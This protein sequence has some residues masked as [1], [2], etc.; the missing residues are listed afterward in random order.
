[1]FGVKSPAYSIGNS[2]RE[3][4][5][6]KLVPGPASY[7]ITRDPIPRSISFNRAKKKTFL[8]SENPG[9][10]SYKINSSIGSG[11]HAIIISR[12]FQK[13]DQNVPGPG[14]YNPLDPIHNIKYSIRSKSNSTIINNNPGP[15]AYNIFTQSKHSPR[16][17]I[18][19]AIRMHEKYEKTPGP[20]A[21]DPKAV[22]PKIPKFS[23]PL[24]PKGQPIE[25]SNLGPGSYEYG[26][27]TNRGKS[28]VIVPRRPE[29]AK[30]TKIPGPGSY[31]VKN[32][33]FSV[34]KWTIPKAK[35]DESFVNDLP[36]PADYSP[37]SNLLHIPNYSIGTSLRINLFKGTL[38]P[39]PGTYEVSKNSEG[40]KYTMA[41]KHK[42]TVS[43]IVPG[44]G[45]YNFEIKK[46]T[47]SAIFG[48]SKKKSPEKSEKEEIPG[49]GSYKTAQ[50][51][52][53]PEYSFSRQKKTFVQISEIPGPGHYEIPSTVGLN[54]SC[55]SLNKSF[56]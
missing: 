45:Q 54:H 56:T 55:L 49:P 20:G 29:T 13:N 51:L 28:A 40:P 34:P 19:K 31:N 32:D 10:G 50:E 52:K 36:S 38:I 16:A 9:P 35:K 48:T 12:K 47:P 26:L 6:E 21:Y 41:S 39:G 15:G 2:R 46:R 3:L 23:F 14:N 33:P 18:G 4:S 43:E 22:K 5:I 17:A 37:K 8:Y 42:R 25:E 1:M 24:S 44:P 7:S 27:S 30:N 11:P 53:G